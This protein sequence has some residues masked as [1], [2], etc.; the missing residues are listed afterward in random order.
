MLPALRG[1]GLDIVTVNIGD[2]AAV[3]K[4]YWH[5]AGLNL[6]VLMDT[7]TKVAEKYKVYGIPSGYLIGSNGKILARFAGFDEATMRQALA[8]AGIQ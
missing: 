4:K 6:R 5:E 3:I 8:K 2:S 1:K 7:D